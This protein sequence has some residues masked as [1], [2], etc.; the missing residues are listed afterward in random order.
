MEVSVTIAGAGDKPLIVTG[1][2]YGDI[3]DAV[4]LSPQEASVLVDGKPVPADAP[5][6][7]SEVTVL[8][9]IAGG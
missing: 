2:T 1:E 7:A 4:E 9:L 3:L 5:V 6:T 8:R